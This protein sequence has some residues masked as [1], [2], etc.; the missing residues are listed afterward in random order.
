MTMQHWSTVGLPRLCSF[1]LSTIN[2]TVF[3]PV[4]LFVC[5]HGLYLPLLMPL[6]QLNNQQGC[7][8]PCPFSIYIFTPAY[9]PKMTS[10]I[11]I[12]ALSCS[13]PNR[14]RLYIYP[15]SV[16]PHLYLALG[17]DSIEL[18]K[19]TPSPLPPPPPPL[20]LLEHQNLFQYIWPP[21]VGG[22]IQE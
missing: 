9:A 2:L 5:T 4:P 7:M 18:I 3:I 6:L 16:P 14:T 11:S 17:C 1:P 19:P 20:R 12:P 8:Y 21:I 13:L 10:S 22:I 15:C